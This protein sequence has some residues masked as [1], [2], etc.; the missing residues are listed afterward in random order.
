MRL[1][2][3]LSGGRRGVAAVDEHGARRLAGITDVRQLA[4]LAY[5]QDC[6][7]AELAVQRVEGPPLEMSRLLDEGQILSPLDHP[8]PAHCVVSG[9]GLNHLGS[10]MARDAMHD[11]GATDKPESDSLRMFRLGV[12]GGKPAP[13][14]IGVAPE[15]FYKGD[16]SV[17]VA[18]GGELPYP[19]FADDAGEEAEVVALYVVGQDGTPLRVGYALGN[20][21]SD[22]VLER[23]NY[24]YLAHSKLR[25][26]S[27]GPE[28]L[29]GD[30]PSDLTG[31]VR[32]LRDTRPLW[33]TDFQTGET[34]MSH[35]LANLEYHHFKYPQFR[36]PGDVHCHFLGAAVLSCAAGIVCQPGDVFEISA[37]QFGLP[38]RNRLGQRLGAVA[39]VVHGL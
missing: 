1:I 20:E 13:G 24:L 5:A 6:S 4:L 19:G 35:S 25:A 21:Y 31:R 12:A 26:C 8:D 29:L 39:P 9:T 10:A 15:W 37:A 11:A 7:L 33:E 3:F 17:V 30:L 32:V 2:Q 27:F 23:R 22:H 14:Q 34:H 38:L 36:R 16:G 18:P 28:L